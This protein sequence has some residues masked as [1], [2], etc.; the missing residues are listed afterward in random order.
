M[1]PVFIYC[2]IINIIVFYICQLPVSHGVLVLDYFYVVL[3][4]HN[5]AASLYLVV[6]NVLGMNLPSDIHI[7]SSMLLHV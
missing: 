3:D 6:E 7:Y 4:N 1:C 2:Y 5:I